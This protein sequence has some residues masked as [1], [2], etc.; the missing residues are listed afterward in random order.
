MYNNLEDKNYLG[1]WFITVFGFLSKNYDCKGIGSNFR[2]VKGGDKQTLTKINTR[3]EGI[4]ILRYLAYQHLGKGSLKKYP[5]RYF[6]FQGTKINIVIIETFIFKHLDMADSAS[7]QL[8]YSDF[9]LH[10]RSTKLGK[11]FFNDHQSHDKR[12]Y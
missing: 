2:Q 1:M 10:F 12:R 5:E 3:I 11:I 7:N 9:E 6:I 4:K 8:M